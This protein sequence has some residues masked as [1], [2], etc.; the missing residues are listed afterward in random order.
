[1]WNAQT[2]NLLYLRFLTNENFP[3]RFIIAENSHICQAHI[4]PKN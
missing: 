1:M 3:R 2:K 4:C